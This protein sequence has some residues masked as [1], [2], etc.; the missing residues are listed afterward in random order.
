MF[1]QSFQMQNLHLASLQRTL[2]QGQSAA[3][4]QRPPNLETSAGAGHQS[5][6]ETK[7]HGP[8]ISPFSPT[9]RGAG[10]AAGDRHLDKEELQSPQEE[11]DLDGDELIVDVENDA[12]DPENS[13]NLDLHQ[14]AASWR[15]LD[16]LHCS[17]T[18]NRPNP[19]TANHRHH[20][21]QTAG[22]I[23]LPSR[24]AGERAPTELGVALEQSLGRPEVWARASGAESS[25]RGGPGLESGRGG[26]S[27]LGAAGRACPSPT[28][29][30]CEIG[31]RAELAHPHEPGARPHRPALP[32]AASNGCRSSLQLD[33]PVQPRDMQSLLHES[34]FA[35]FLAQLSHTTHNQPPKSPHESPNQA[36]HTL[37]S[38]HLGAKSAAEQAL[39]SYL[40]LLDR[41]NR[42]PSLEHSSAPILAASYQS[43]LRERQAHGAPPE[44]CHQVASNSPRQ[45]TREE[46]QQA[47]NCKLLARDRQTNL[48]DQSMFTCPYV[49]ASPSTCLPAT[50]AARSS[51]TSLSSSAA[52]PNG[53]HLNLNPY[54][55]SDSSSLNVTLGHDVTIARP[56]AALCDQHRRSASLMDSCQLRPR[57]D[58]SLEQHPPVSRPS[59]CS[60]GQVNEQRAWPETKLEE[61]EAD[62]Q[63]LG[64][65]GADSTPASHGQRSRKIWRTFDQESSPMDDDEHTGSMDNLG[66]CFDEETTNPMVSGN[67]FKD[68]QTLI[69]SC[70]QQARRALRQPE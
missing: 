48:R 47:T 41:N 24:L 11:R 18:A 66:D 12:S 10:Q 28:A 16:H 62:K 20:S 46:E 17:P 51:P 35:S 4:P 64:L 39:L 5:R 60:F 1:Q 22:S 9:L 65:L 33:E 69:A 13:D 15:L 30:Q 45:Q 34:L 68:I 29:A 8:P 32:A 53:L 27:G 43:F 58:L 14:E 49:P 38:G 26:W 3:P 50:N 55:N 2:C 70:S 67:N 54:L 63:Q 23:T 36:P 31:A 19:S 52:P 25:Q 37:A 57:T 21:G 40:L 6:A 59:D 44:L 7:L 56:Q 61:Q 42:E